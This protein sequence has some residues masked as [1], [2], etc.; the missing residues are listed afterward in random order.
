MNKKEQLIFNEKIILLNTKWKHFQK[1]HPQTDLI[2]IYIVLKGVME[3]LKNITK[4]K[5]D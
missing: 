3:T 1:D 5:Y 2:D 4:N